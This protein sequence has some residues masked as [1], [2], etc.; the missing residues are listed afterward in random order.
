MKRTVHF[1]GACD[2]CRQPISLDFDFGGAG[3]IDYDVA[4]DGRLF[5][6]IRHIGGPKRGCTIYSSTVYEVPWPRD[7]AVMEDPTD[8]P[9][10]SGEPTIGGIRPGPGT[11]H[12][13]TRLTALLCA[14][15]ALSAQFRREPLGTHDGQM[16]GLRVVQAWDAYADDNPPESDS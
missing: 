4:E 8:I 11:G 10:D 13:P 9:L 1:E 3:I 2:V 15:E 16:A 12:V 7:S 5:T 14:A 6:R